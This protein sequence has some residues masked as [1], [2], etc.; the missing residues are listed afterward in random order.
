MT[1]HLST[2][3]GDSLVV[4]QVYRS[5]GMTVQ[6]FDTQANLNVLDIVDFNMIL[7]MDY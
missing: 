7:Y 1:L 3:M 2:P 4:G 5:S 6:K